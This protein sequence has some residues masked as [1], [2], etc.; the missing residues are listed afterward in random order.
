MI[1]IVQ[2]VWQKLTGL[3]WI[4]SVAAGMERLLSPEL[5]ASDVIVTNA[6]GVTG[7]SLAE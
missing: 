2:D 6:R 4:H 1:C 3:K 7:Q 5:V